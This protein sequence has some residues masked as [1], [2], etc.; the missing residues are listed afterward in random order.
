MSEGEVR[1]RTRRPTCCG[2]VMSE[3]VGPRHRVVSAAG[4]A[5]VYER[6]LDEMVVLVGFT[7]VAPRS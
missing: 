4:A 1:A 2:A 3:I 7:D 5:A 6:A